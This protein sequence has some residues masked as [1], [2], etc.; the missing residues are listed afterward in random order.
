MPRERI[1]EDQKT[2]HFAQI[3]K[4][5]EPTLDLVEE[6]CTRVAQGMPATAVC[7]YLG[8]R[9]SVFQ[10]WRRLGTSYIDGRPL[11]GA[12]EIHGIFVSGLKRACAEWIDQRV[13][14]VQ[15]NAATWF[16]DLKLL[17][18]RDRGNFSETVQGG[19]DDQVDPNESFL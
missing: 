4:V 16:R 15:N 17:Q 1:F 11:A 5:N 7:D 10:H 2:Y 12:S 9:D 6:F 18:I 14:G 13:Q 19:Q 8:I 3:R